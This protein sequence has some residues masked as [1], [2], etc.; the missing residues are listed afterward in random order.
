VISI[1]DESVTEVVAVAEQPAELVTVTVYVVLAV[2]AVA[3]GLAI[4]VLERNVAGDHE[5]VYDGGVN[6]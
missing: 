6:L 2:T 1:A 4:V 5:Y 3:T